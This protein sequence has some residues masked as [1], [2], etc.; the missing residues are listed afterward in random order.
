MSLGFISNP[1]N[2]YQVATPV[3]EGPLD[4]LLSLIERA[5][6]DITKL[7]L[8]QVTDQYL[9]YLQNLS[10]RSAE[11]VSAFLVIAAR[12]IQIKSE[13]LLPRP[14]PR[15]PDEEDLGEALARQLLAYKRFKEVANGLAQRQVAGLKTYLSLAPVIKVE[16]Q[17]D[18]S[19]L[20]W[21][22]L[23]ARCFHWPHNAKH[24]HRLTVWCQPQR[25]LSARK[26][27]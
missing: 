19:G 10:Q 8:A 17:V 27:V 22:Q 13:A 9:A 23:P 6:L 20:I 3:Y 14:P 11:Q 15:E 16:G 4:L 26:S 25:Y 12:L 2:T 5:E 1:I 7:A 21:S 24:K 18:L